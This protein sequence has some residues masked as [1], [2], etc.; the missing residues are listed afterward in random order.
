MSNTASVSPETMHNRK[1][2]KD[3]VKGLKEKLYQ[4]KSLH[5]MKIPY[6]NED[7]R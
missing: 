2:W 5:P 1:Q 4:T 7:K 3:I 6:K